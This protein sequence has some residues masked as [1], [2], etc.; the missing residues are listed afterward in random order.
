MAEILDGKKISEEIVEKL[1]QKRHSI[2]GVVKL[3][4][5]LVGDN[6]ASLSYVQQKKKMGEDIGVKVEV[7]EYDKNISTKKLRKEVGMIC[8]KSDMKGVIVQLPLPKSINTRA[9]VNAILPQ[10]DVDLLSAKYVG[11]IY[12]NKNKLLPPTI[13]SILT[14]CEKYDIDINNKVA[15][16]VGYGI[17]VGKPAS[18]ILGN[19]GITVLNIQEN[20]K[21]PKEILQL[22]DII[23]TGVGKPNTIKKDMVKGG[24]VVLDA[25][26]SKAG[27]KIV[28]DVSSDVYKKCSYYSPVPD[29]IGILTVAKLF[30]NLFDI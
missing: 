29:G 11:E 14:L 18:V 5:V 20:T 19:M 7:F 2:K 24:A 6:P 8:R 13:A 16:V 12:T 23:I 21:N 22:A 28:G 27:D 17:L 3:G 26:F 1:K 9:V 25:G 30:E 10:V 4:I 15:G